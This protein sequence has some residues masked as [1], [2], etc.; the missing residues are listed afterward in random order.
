MKTY[1]KSQRNKHTSNSTNNTNLSKIPKGSSLM[2]LKDMIN[3]D[4][5]TNLSNTPTDKTWILLLLS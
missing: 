3:F 5:L 2:W 1:I 4:K